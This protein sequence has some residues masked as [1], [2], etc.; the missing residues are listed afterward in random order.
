ML[1]GYK[2][3][4]SGEAAEQQPSKQASIHTH[5]FTALS[6]SLSISCVLHSHM[7]MKAFITPGIG[8]DPTNEYRDENVKWLKQPGKQVHTLTSQAAA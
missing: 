3:P 6:P 5:H 4:S 2:R 1:R 8:V 7:G